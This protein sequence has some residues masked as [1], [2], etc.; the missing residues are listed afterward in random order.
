VIV[1]DTTVWVDFLRAKGTAFDLHLELRHWGQ[2]FIFDFGL[3]SM[4]ND[5]MATQ[6]EHL[7]ALRTLDK[8]F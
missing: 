5:R 8:L 6:F 2:I 3:F 1:V 4:L 7:F